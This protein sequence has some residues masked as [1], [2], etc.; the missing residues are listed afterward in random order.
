V[1]IN[2][3]N[4][5]QSGFPVKIEQNFKIEGEQIIVMAISPKRRK[6]YARVAASKERRTEIRRQRRG[7]KSAAKPKLMENNFSQRDLE[8]V[9]RARQTVERY[10]KMPEGGTPQSFVAFMASV[11]K[12]KSFFAKA[13]PRIDARSEFTPDTV[14]DAYQ[15]Q[16]K[17]TGANPLFSDLE[18][19]IHIIQ[20]QAPGTDWREVAYGLVKEVW[21]PK[22]AKQ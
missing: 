4:T 17:G 21:K 20:T 19:H 5:N 3:L 12:L 11:T 15:H 9:T 8:Q 14:I 1:P 2:E 6:K 16:Y 7:K 22:E 18:M 10:A 13:V